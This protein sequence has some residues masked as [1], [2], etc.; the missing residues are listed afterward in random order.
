[1]KSLKAKGSFVGNGKIIVERDNMKDTL[2]GIFMGSI[3]ILILVVSVIG[4]IM[5]NNIVKNIMEPLGYRATNMD[6]GNGNRQPTVCYSGYF[7]V[8]YYNN[9]GMLNVT[10]IDS[11]TG[12]LVSGPYTISTNVDKYRRTAITYDGENILVV[13]RSSTNKSLFGRILNYNGST[14]SREFIINNSATTVGATDFDVVGIPQY[15]IFVIVWS[16]AGYHNHYR[17][18]QD[19]NPVKMGNVGSLSDDTKSHA[20]NQIGYDSFTGNV[21]VLWRRYDSTGIYNVT[22]RIFRVDSKNLTLSPVT[23]DFTVGDGVTSKT[24]YDYPSIAGGGGYFFVA[25][26]NYHSPYE[27]YGRIVNASD[28]SMDSVFQ[29]GSTGYSG[30]GYTGIAFNG[31]NFVVVWTNGD[32]NIVARSYDLSGNPTTAIQMIA[33][34]SHREETPDVAVDTTDRTYYFVWHDYTSGRNYGSL[35]RGDVFVPELSTII[36]IAV[37]ASIILILKRRKHPF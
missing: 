1:M 23:N 6:L 30:R 10:F 7:V 5:H 9:S 32:Y 21:M 16:D 36:L 34:T 31:T 25:F 35:W 12:N 22:G 19:T 20:R 18:I 37:P 15:K 4:I 3:I 14:I 11:T 13:W 27:V 24:Q 8:A 26:T 33:E 2:L 28:G 17:I 29:I